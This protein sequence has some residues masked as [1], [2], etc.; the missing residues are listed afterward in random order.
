MKQFLLIFALTLLCFQSY[1]DGILENFET[2]LQDPFNG[3]SNLTWIGDVGDFEITTA[4]W[5]HYTSYDFMGSY[6]TRSK[7]RNIADTSIILVDI[8]SVYSSSKKIRWEVYICGNSAEITTGSGAS[9]VLF[10]NSNSIDD[11]KAGLVNGY[12]LR[13]CDPSGIS[14]WKDG[15]YFEKANGTE[16]IMID[17][18]H[19][20]DANINQG[21]NIVVERDINGNWSWGYA[22]GA[23]G[24]AVSLTESI[25]DNTYI[26]GQYSGIFWYSSAGDSDDFGF[27]NFKIDPYTP[28]L[29]KGE[30]GSTDWSTASNWDDGV[31]PNAT[32]D[33]QIEAGV[34]QPNIIDNTS[35]NNLV[36]EA[37]ANLTVS[38]EITLSV[39]GNFTLQS[40]ADGTASIIDHGTLSVSGN[41]KIQRYMKCFDPNANDEYHFLSIPIASH[42]VENYLSH[43]YVYPYDETQN[44]WTYLSSGDQI[45]KGMAYSVY[46]SG[47]AHHCIEF[48]G[49]PNTGNQTILITATDFSEDDSND[50]WNLIGNPFPS[51]IDWDEV[52]KDNIEGAIYMWDAESCSYASYVSGAGTNFNDDGIIPAM[53]GFFVHAIS[54]GNLTIPQSARVHNQSQD[55]MMKSKSYNPSLRIKIKDQ[56]YADECV[57]R[58]KSGANEYWDTD[59]DAYKFLSG[60]AEVPQIYSLIPHEIKASI[61]TLSDEINQYEIP[62]FSRIEN[63]GQYE[64]CI[65]NVSSFIHDYDIV[66]QNVINGDQYT[67]LK[68]SCY[69][70][71]LMAGELEHFRLL[72]DAK[73]LAIPEEKTERIDISVLHDGIVKV[74]HIPD[75]FIDGKLCVFSLDGK[76]LFESIVNDQS[77]QFSIIPKGIFLIQLQS[78]QNIYTQKI[79]IL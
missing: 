29:W 43:Y 3:I 50:N 24:T 6:A 78:K 19:T 49:I 28:N 12:R 45:I 1:A 74:E 42:N 60:K 47:D 59:F 65:S 13:L 40:D 32:A 34:N 46:Y 18:I 21:W 39:N 14:G 23:M 30:A 41:T 55:F 51:P 33:I 48:S 58:L 53:Q 67:I 10:T 57:I 8:T 68:D 61:N 35:C 36:L 16:W 63:E 25:I 72:L 37:G 17:S 56:N 44:A 7:D 75:E 71:Y 9:L 76:C 31:L 73:K 15:L 20:G 77:M 69:Q 70:L 38:P 54:D 5:T 64:I 62:L 26:I 27:D 4:G 11:I 79:I 66:L 52:T 22:N 2:G